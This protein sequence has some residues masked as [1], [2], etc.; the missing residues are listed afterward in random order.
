MGGL[1]GVAVFM[2]GIYYGLVSCAH[3]GYAP[4]GNCN[5]P[6]V[7]QAGSARLAKNDPQANLPAGAL[8]ADA[9]EGGRGTGAYARAESAFAHKPMQVGL[10]IHTHAADASLVARLDPA[11]WPYSNIRSLGRLAQRMRPHTVLSHATGSNSPIKRWCG[12]CYVGC[13]IL[14]AVPTAAESALVRAG[15]ELVGCKLV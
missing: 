12:K 1:V 14:H 15:I 7:N 5:L 2:L 8:V 4:L 6:G 13:F 3:G 9:L 11:S 10:L